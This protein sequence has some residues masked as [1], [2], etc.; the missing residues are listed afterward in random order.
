MKMNIQDIKKNDETSQNK[1]TNQIPIDDESNN[2]D[3]LPIG[4]R[5][6]KTYS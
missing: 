4:L 2:N 1:D 5:Q 6:I 3:D